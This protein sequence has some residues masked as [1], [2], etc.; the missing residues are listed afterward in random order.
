M[1][2]SL[3][4]RRLR[5]A[6]GLAVH[7]I[8]GRLRRSYLIQCQHKVRAHPTPKRQVARTA[9]SPT[10]K[11]P[12]SKVSQL[13]PRWQPRLA[14]DRRILPSRH[15]RHKSLPR[16]ERTCHFTLSVQRN[17]LGHDVGVVN[18]IRVP[19]VLIADLMPPR[20]VTRRRLS[21]VNVLKASA[22]P[23]HSTRQTIS[24]LG[25]RVVQPTQRFFR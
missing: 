4:T 9:V 11:H 19:V 2:L 13:R 25:S 23:R 21:T 1:R 7:R 10:L 20:I 17:V 12:R 5:G 6:I 3:D 24:G 8:K 14:T 16:V 18:S 15:F 22:N